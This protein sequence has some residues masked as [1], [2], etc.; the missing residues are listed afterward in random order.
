MGRPV[1]LYAAKMF[2]VTKYHMYESIYQGR[3]FSEDK[4]KNDGKKQVIF[5]T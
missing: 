3:V 1:C 4:T 2:I 5:A